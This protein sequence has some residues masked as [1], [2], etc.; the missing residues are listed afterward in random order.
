MRAPPSHDLI[1]PHCLSE[2]SSPNAISSQAESSTYQSEHSVH[3]SNCIMRLLWGLKELEHSKNMARCKCSH[4]R[5]SPSPLFSVSTCPQFQNNALHIF[6]IW[7]SINICWMSEIIHHHQIKQW[8]IVPIPKHQCYQVW[9]LSL[10]VDV[11]TASAAENGPSWQLIVS[12]FAIVSLKV[13]STLWPLFSHPAMPMVLFP[14]S[15]HFSVTPNHETLFPPSNL[16]IWNLLW[17]RISLAANRTLKH[18]ISSL[19]L[20]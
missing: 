18:S 5:L 19:Y 11:R 20:H 4:V 16:I 9:A 7:C 14:E 17:F 15:C 1:N 13:D 8:L 2:A 10:N 3:S 12:C 6:P